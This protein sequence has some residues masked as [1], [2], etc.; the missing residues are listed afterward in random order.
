MTPSLAFVQT[1]FIEF[2]T[3]IFKGALNPL[4]IR[5]GSSKTRLGSISYKRRKQGN[6]FEFYDFKL[7]ISKRFDLPKNEVE[8]TIIH[9]MIHYYI[10]SKQLHDTSPHGKLFRQLMDHINKHFGRHI[11][12]SHH[13]TGEE[14]ATDTH[15]KEHFVCVTV[16]TDGRTGLTVSA[17]TR[18][19]QMWRNL[20]KYYKLQKMTWYWSIDPFFNQF[21]NSI[22][23]RI[24]LV[25]AE[26]LNSHL[27][28]AKE[29][30]CDGTTF[31]L[32]K[33]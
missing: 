22:T 25:D 26:K 31:R 28:D 6:T 23:P 14:R 5:I 10:L 33:D 8:D 2:N 27:K 32:K 9:E 16:L 24:Y 21:P 7:T 19:F 12:I 15:I 20:P 3:L 4:P 13:S 17:K 29:L 11:T 30:E 18:I 1:K